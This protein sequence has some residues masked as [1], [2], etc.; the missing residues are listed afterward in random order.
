VIG[1]THRFYDLKLRIRYLVFQGLVLQA[2]SIVSLYLCDNHECDHVYDDI[3]SVAD[4]AEEQHVSGI[5]EE[6]AVKVH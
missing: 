6:G 2:P 1:L 5:T 4:C 3:L